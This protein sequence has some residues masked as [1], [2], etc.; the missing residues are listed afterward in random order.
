MQKY[1]RISK[2]L[3]LIYTKH[4]IRTTNITFVFHQIPPCERE[5][6]GKRLKKVKIKTHNLQD[7]S[8]VYWLTE[9]E[10]NEYLIYF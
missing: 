5:R 3:V 1:F 8:V 4:N 7:F 6:G 2:F 10:D 9:Y